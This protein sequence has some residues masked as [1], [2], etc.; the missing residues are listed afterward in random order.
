M[1][2]CTGI[3]PDS[4]NQVTER[5]FGEVNVFW[6]EPLCLQVKDCLEAVVKA[7]SQCLNA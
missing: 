4:T 5:K 1:R 3:K 2:L 7:R 6:T